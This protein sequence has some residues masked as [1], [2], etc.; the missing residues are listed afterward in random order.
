MA[1]VFLPGI[2][3]HNPHRRH[4]QGNSQVVAQRHDLA[5]PQAGFQLYFKLSDHW[6]SLN[7]YHF[8]P[9]AEVCK[10]LFQNRCLLPYIAFVLFEAK[11]LTGQEQI[12]G[13][14]T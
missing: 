1:T 14:R 10:R 12:Q 4:P 6:P 3:G 2:G 11:R 7:L 9:V 8:H 5:D 13:G